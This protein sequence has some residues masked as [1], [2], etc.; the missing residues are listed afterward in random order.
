MLTIDRLPHVCLLA[1][2]NILST[3][4]LVNVSLT[5]R[6]II[7]YINF[8]ENK[9]VTQQT[10]SPDHRIKDQGSRIKDQGSVQNE[11]NKLNKLIGMI[12]CSS[13]WLSQDLSLLT[14]RR[15]T[16]DRKLD[17]KLSILDSRVVVGDFLLIVK[18]NVCNFILSLEKWKDNLFF[19]IHTNLLHRD[20]CRHGQWT[21][22]SPLFSN[23]L[24]FHPRINLSNK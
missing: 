4:D 21:T 2:F 5:C 9:A 17:K 14:G 11:S 23:F 7:S 1:L 13:T 15:C 19:V 8:T 6:S 22:K 18:A 10:G 3:L 16:L 20:I 24:H 12:D